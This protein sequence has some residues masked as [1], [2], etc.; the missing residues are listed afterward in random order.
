MTY[1]SI[2][3]E[4]QTSLST[5]ILQRAPDSLSRGILQRGPTAGSPA[6]TVEHLQ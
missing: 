5:G 3:N 6:A 2:K 4:L 1:S